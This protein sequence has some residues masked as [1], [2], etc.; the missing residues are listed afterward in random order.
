[1]NCLV[2]RNI[3][4]IKQAKAKGAIWTATGTFIKPT[5]RKV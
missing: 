3:N 5:A 4:L 1:M 2:L